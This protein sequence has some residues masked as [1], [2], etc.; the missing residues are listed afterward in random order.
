MDRKSE[1]ELRKA[2]TRAIKKVIEL[3]K[4]ESSVIIIEDSPEG[5]T[6]FPAGEIAAWLF[7]RRQ[8][9]DHSGR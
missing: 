3:A 5:E 9:D 4:L 6:G 2:A 8:D 7:R 1:R